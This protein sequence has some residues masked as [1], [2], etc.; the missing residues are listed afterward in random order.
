MKGTLWSWIEVCPFPWKFSVN[1]FKK[2]SNREHVSIYILSYVQWSKEFMESAERM[3]SSTKNTDKLHGEIILTWCKMSFHLVIQTCYQL[4]V[5]WPH[6]L[7]SRV[8]IFLHHGLTTE[9]INLYQVWPG[10]L[11]SHYLYI[12][13][14]SVTFRWTISQNFLEHI[15]MNY[16]V[17]QNPFW[18]ADILAG[19][20]EI[21]R[22][23]S[24]PF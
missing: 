11:H 15:L 13:L 8:K 19:A 12:T 17:D 21:N 2:V 3:T 14:M 5:A 24:L 6:L 22:E 1:D 4:A 9:T 18:E 23:G 20:Q 7:C 10:K 16:P